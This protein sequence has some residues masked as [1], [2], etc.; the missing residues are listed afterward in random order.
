MVSPF[1]AH[2]RSAHLLWPARLLLLW[3]LRLLWLRCTK[4]ERGLGLIE[5]RLIEAWL[6]EAWLRNRGLV[7]TRHHRSS[8]GRIRG[9][10]TRSV[11]RL[12]L[13][14]VLLI[15]VLLI[16]VLLVLLSG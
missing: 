7:E 14:R 1:R 13:I 6:I 10:P 9:L 8:I 11:G 3:L 5:S 15:R 4:S 2:I 12:R 16:R